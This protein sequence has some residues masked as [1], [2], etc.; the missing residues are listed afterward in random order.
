MDKIRIIDFDKENSEYIEQA[1]KLMFGAFNIISPNYCNT[2][3]KARNAVREFFDVTDCLRIA[4]IDG[5]VTGIIG[6]IS[7][8]HGNVYE[9]HPVAVD[10]NY[11]RQGI[12]RMLLKDMEQII[13]QLGGKT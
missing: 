6:C 3:E 4:V 13:Y 9:L 12:G 11:Q 10:V 2:M 1:A 8:Y 7:Q 5:K